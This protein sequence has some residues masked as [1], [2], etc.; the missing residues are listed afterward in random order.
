MDYAELV[1]ASRRERAL[2]EELAA[3]YRAMVGVLRDEHAPVDPA[4]VAA[5]G[6]RA[7]AA[8]AALRAVA[9]R[10]APHRLGGDTVP[11]E[12]EAL[13]R[14]S[15]ALAAEAAQTNADI[16]GLARA[17]QR[18]LADHL[19]RLGDGRRGL[20]GYRPRGERPAPITDQRA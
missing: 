6:A 14:A 4:W 3:A 13:W 7:E 19:A 10:L 8:T 17:R 2:Y 12:A 16:I 1:G 9:A 15:A 5:H 18:R 20:A 11:A